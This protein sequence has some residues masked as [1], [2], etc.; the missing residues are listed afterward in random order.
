MWGDAILRTIVQ[1]PAR[2]MTH[3]GQDRSLSDAVAAQAIG[4][5]PPRF[6]LWPTQQALEET[7][8][9]YTVS[10]ILRSTTTPC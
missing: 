5:E 9:G 2:P 10:P 6:V 1:V 4:D 7:L 8:G 3:I